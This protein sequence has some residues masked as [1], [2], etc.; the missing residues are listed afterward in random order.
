MKRT[1]LS[2]DE[3]K[4]LR[5]VPVTAASPNRVRVAMAMLDLTQTD[6]ARGTNRSQASI[7][8]I[9]NFVSTDVKLPTLHALAAFFGCTVD[10][11]FP[12]VPVRHSSER[13]TA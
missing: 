12:C 8:D 2:G 11:L 7:S 9:C 3:L 4:A 13:A 10:D 1:Q 6:V 5:V